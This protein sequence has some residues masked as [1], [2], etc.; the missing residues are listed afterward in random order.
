MATFV[1]I[2]NRVLRRLRED[3]V[4]NH[5]D[6]PYST[7]VSDM[8]NETIAEMQGR[9]EWRS[10]VDQFTITTD[11]SSLV[12]ALTS[13]ESAASR[14][15]NDQLRIRN[16]YSDSDDYDLIKLNYAGISR[17]KLYTTSPDNLW[18]YREVGLDTSDRRKIELY[19]DVASKTV[20]VEAYNPHAELDTS[21]AQVLLPQRVA[22]LG[23]YARAVDERGEDA[24]SAAASAWNLYSN[25]LA[26]AVITEV[27]RQTDLENDWRPV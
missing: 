26:D 1:T 8:L 9:C 12:Y 17:S 4:S 27:E 20:I 14:D 3:E 24:G 22:F 23:T 6:T 2:V 18:G 10:L 15:S 16:V 25:L 21:S 11:G 19:P 13:A 5:D 7:L